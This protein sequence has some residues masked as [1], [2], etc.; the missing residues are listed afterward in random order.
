[1]GN[2][3]RDNTTVAKR[4][5]LKG[6]LKSAEKQ[7]IYAEDSINW[8]LK[9]AGNDSYGSVLKSSIRAIRSVR[10][11]IDKAKEYISNT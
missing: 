5:I 9:Y 10:E 11:T 6:E 1:M 3:R 7:L 8:F 2:K 4:A